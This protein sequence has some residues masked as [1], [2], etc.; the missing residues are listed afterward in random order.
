M[1]RCYLDGAVMAFRPV[2]LEIFE[3]YYLVGCQKAIRERRVSI[4][5]F[6]IWVIWNQF[7]TPTLADE[8]FYASPRRVV[9]SFV[10]APAYPPYHV[11]VWKGKDSV[12]LHRIFYHTRQ[13]ALILLLNTPIQNLRWGSISVSQFSSVYYAHLSGHLLGRSNDE[14]VSSRSRKKHA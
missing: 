9:D 12:I 11:R 1:A 5:S 3:A 4:L 6:K 8:L 14:C 2:V 7:S 13:C 10:K